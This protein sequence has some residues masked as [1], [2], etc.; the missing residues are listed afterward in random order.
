M[1][2]FGFL[3]ASQHFGHGYDCPLMPGFAC[4]MNPAEHLS[5]VQ[6]NFSSIVPNLFMLITVALVA[7][8][9]SSRLRLLCRSRGRPSRAIFLTPRTLQELYSQGI[10]NPKAP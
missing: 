10:L 5:L 7:W 6:K 2:S 3:I 9:Y 1:G 4:I 8:F